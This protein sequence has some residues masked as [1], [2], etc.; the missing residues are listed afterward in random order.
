MNISQVIL[1]V[2]STSPACEP[3]MKFISQAR[4]PVMPVRLDTN[5]DRLRAANGKEFQIKIVPTLL[6]VYQDKNIQLFVGQEKTMQWLQKI[7]PPT[8]PPQQP[9]FDDD[10]DYDMPAREQ[11]PRRKKKKKKKKSKVSLGRGGL[12]DGK[13]KKKKKPPIEFYDSSEEES[14][15]EEVEIEFVDGDDDLQQPPP[16]QG[17]MVGP[18]STKSSGHKN[19]SNLMALAEQMKNERKLTLGYDESKLPKS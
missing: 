8:P 7:A 14:G 2:S 6:V 4:L 12:Y 5:E 19:S 9:Q 1:F 3:C 17:L 16:I 11:Q 13:K 15:G 18:G 10:D